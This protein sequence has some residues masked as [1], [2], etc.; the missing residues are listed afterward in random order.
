MTAPAAIS[1]LDNGT[2]LAGDRELADLFDRASSVYSYRAEQRLEG[3]RAD[4]CV[5]CGKPGEG[6]ECDTCL[7]DGDSVVERSVD[8]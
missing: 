2:A 8:V 5:I 3:F 7:N 6:R 4:Q 1:R